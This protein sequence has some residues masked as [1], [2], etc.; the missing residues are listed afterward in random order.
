ML[1]MIIM[2][3]MIIVMIIT[4]IIMI[5]IIMI[6]LTWG[7]T[8]VGLCGTTACELA[9]KKA[10]NVWTCHRYHHHYCCHRCHH[11]RRHHQKL[12]HPAS[13]IKGLD[14]G[15]RNSDPLRRW[16]WVHLGHDGADVEDALDHG[17]AGPRHGDCPLRWVRQHLTR[18]LIIVLMVV[19]VVIV[20]MVVVA[21]MR[22]EITTMLSKQPTPP[23]TDPPSNYDEIKSSYDE[24]N[25]WME[26]PVISRISLI[27]EPPF[28]IREP[29]WNAKIVF[30][31][32][33]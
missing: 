1:P 29:H 14:R 32:K 23:P 21:R 10:G 7:C 28:P 33:N 19:M 22:M 2:I 26:A 12:T 17:L 30:G 3:I 15:V 8:V 18:H 25:T 6:L 9:G 16:L 31:E 13:N 11:H 20:V 27:F 24:S 5:M 4:I